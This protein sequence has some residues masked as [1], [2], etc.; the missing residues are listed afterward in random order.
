M[1]DTC[2][3]SLATPLTDGWLKRHAR[4]GGVLAFA[5]FAQLI[6]VM[7]V[8]I[9]PLAVRGES[10]AD[11]ARVAAEKGDAA[12]QFRYAEML[13]TGNGVA[14]NLTE[15]AEGTL[16]ADISRREIS[17]SRPDFLV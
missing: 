8:S 5:M 6:G 3:D 15:A 13:R 9:S 10:A 16:K 1:N 4:I 14:S 12:A 2:E 11:A 7:F 17:V